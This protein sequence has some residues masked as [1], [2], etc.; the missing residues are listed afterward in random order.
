[1]DEYI[2][3]VKLFAG[4]FA[5]RNWAI[6]DGSLLSIAQNSAVFAILGT[7][8]GGNGTTTFALPDLRGRAAIGFGQGP[9][10]QAYTQGQGGGTEQVT[11]LN[12]QLPAHNHS[13]AASTGTG[14]A[15]SPTNTLLATTT[16][17]TSGGEGVAVNSYSNGTANTALNPTSI[18]M[19]GNNQPH[20]NRPPFL[21]LTYI[22]CLQ[23][24]FP[25][26]D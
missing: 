12:G 23:G 19:A 5:P 4:N 16:G 1:M 9:G 7:T 22:I 24:I 3:I 15:N 26:R 10:L 25:P 11:L 17:T 8:Y 13:L 18:G 14:T 6:C 2:G 21:T 20:E